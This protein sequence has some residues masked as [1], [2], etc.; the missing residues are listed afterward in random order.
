MK[1]SGLLR[2]ASLVLSTFATGALTSCGGGATTP[3]GMAG[4]GGAGVGGAGGGAGTSGGGV[5][6]GGAGTSGGGVGGG[7][8]GTSGGG[9][10]GGGAGTSGV[11]GGAGAGGASSS[12]FC[13]PATMVDDMEDGD[14]ALCP[15]QG[16]SGGWYVTKGSSA[17]TTT[18]VASSTFAAWSLAN[19]P[20]AGS[21]SQYGMRLAGTGFGNDSN[22]DFAGLAFDFAASGTYDLSA[23]AGIKFWI[24]SEAALHLRVNLPTSASRSTT[25][26]GSCTGAGCE[27]HYGRYIDTSASWTQFSIAFNAITQSGWGQ[28]VAK[29]LAHAISL[30]FNYYGAGTDGGVSYDN[31]ASFGFIVDDVQL[32]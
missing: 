14:S 13:M 18:P 31:P 27:D 6:G 12:S 25:Y 21:S 11:G 23:Y 22:V 1:T 30:D 19:D 26:G 2:L 17:G 8:A 28:V 5:G 4:H 32:Y 16:R 15:N 10:A 20:R 3:G 7:G 29:D 24:K 9:V